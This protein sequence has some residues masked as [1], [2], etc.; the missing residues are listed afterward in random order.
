V[1]VN[2]LVSKSDAGGRSAALLIKS[3]ATTTQGG[4]LALSTDTLLIRNPYILN[5]T[6]STAWS[7]SAVDAAEIGVIV[8]A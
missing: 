1:Q 3:G 7:K 6:T 8:A 5:P 4:T 2:G